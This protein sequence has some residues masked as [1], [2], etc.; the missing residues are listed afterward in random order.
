MGVK[1]YKETGEKRAYRKSLYALFSVAAL[2]RRRGQWACG[3]VLRDRLLCGERRCK[4]RVP[5]G[6]NVPYADPP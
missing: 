1:R 4:E 2:V 5:S 6:S 3:A